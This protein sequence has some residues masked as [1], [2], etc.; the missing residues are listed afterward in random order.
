MPLA[1]RLALQNGVYQVLTNFDFAGTLVLVI[2]P[3]L[4]HAGISMQVAYLQ[5]FYQL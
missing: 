4:R 3:A 1:A 2:A 5:L